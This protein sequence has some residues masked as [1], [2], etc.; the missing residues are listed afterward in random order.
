MMKKPLMLALVAAATVFA[1]GAAKASSN[2]YWSIG[3]NAPPIG[4]VISNGPVYGSAPGYYEPAP[5]YYEP[6][7]VYY[8]PPV[9]YRPAPRVYYSPRVIERRAPVGY[10]WGRGDRDHDGIP[11]R[12][13][14]YDNR[15][16]VRGV[17]YADRDHDGIPD[18]YDRYDN[19]TGAR[20]DRDRVGVPDR[21][22][23]RDDRHYNH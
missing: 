23:R 8:P 2:V 22:D 4:T 10:G 7:P 15:Q 14:R 3:I 18:R 13:D 11:N 20:G 16:G 6:A 9:V 21:Y 12:Y 5:V 1:A 19:R 17:S